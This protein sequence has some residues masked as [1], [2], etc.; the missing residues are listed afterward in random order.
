MLLMQ[1][2]V[3]EIALACTC[4]VEIVSNVIAEVLDCRYVMHYDIIEEALKGLI[5]NLCTGKQLIRY[6]FFADKCQGKEGK[7]ARRKLIWT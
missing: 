2:L 6:N 7:K 4:T 1:F 3:L 5:N